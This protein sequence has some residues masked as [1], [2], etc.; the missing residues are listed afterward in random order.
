MKKSDRVRNWDCEA[1][2]HD[3]EF[4]D[5]LVAVLADSWEQADF[6]FVPA[7]DLC[8]LTLHLEVCPHDLGFDIE[9]ELLVCLSELLLLFTAH[10]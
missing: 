5:A 2:L 3:I 4:A 1:H 9:A 6:I 7:S 10:A 8:K